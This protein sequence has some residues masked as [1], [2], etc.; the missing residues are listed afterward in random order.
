[1]AKIVIILGDSGSGKTASL[2]NLP[3]GSAYVLSATG[4]ELSFV[5]KNELPLQKVNYIGNKEDNIASVVKAIATFNEPIV[6]IDDANYLMTFENMK[7]AGEDGWGKY[8]DMAVHFY[9]VFDAISK[10]PGNQIFYIMSH[11]EI[12]DEGRRQMKTVG[13]MLSEKI[14]LEGLS[15][16]VLESSYDDLDG[17]NFTTQR[18]DAKSAAKSPMGMFEADK[19]PNDLYEV[20]K[21]IRKFYGFAPIAKATEKK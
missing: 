15:N 10:K 19:V 17:Y 18:S 11:S 4:K 8:T 7:R 9:E 6:V 14:V 12:S 1:V 13:K 3:K 21:I 5:N 2:R 16:I 20:D